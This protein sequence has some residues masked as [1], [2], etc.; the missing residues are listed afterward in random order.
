LTMLLYRKGKLKQIIVLH[1]KIK[2]V[3]SEAQLQYRFH[4]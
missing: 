1:E 2:I 4:Y 3:E